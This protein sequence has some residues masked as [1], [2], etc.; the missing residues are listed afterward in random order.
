MGFPEVIKAIRFEIGT[1]THIEKRADRN[2]PIDSFVHLN[3]H[4]Q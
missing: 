2:S 1:I 3:L 4:Q